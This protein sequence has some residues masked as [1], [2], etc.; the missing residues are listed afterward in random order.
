MLDLLKALRELEQIEVRMADLY[1]W[2]AGL[3]ADDPE[4]SA[5]FC[6]LQMEEVGHQNILRYEGRIVRANPKAFRDFSFNTELLTRTLQA[7]DSFRKA[8]PQPTLEQALETALIFET[9]A[10]ELY[11]ITIF[12]DSAREFS[13]FVTNLHAASR[14]HFEKLHKFASRRGIDAFSRAPLNE[15]QL[16][17]PAIMTPAAGRQPR[18]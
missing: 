3:F 18:A 12:K 2:Y 4:A 10:A 9:G 6:H 7:I 15:V 1:E 14:T 11:Y 13:Q 17:S 8:E 16:P 5:L